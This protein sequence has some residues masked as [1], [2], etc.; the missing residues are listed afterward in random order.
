[1]VSHVVIAGSHPAPAAHYRATGHRVTELSL[2]DPEA[3]A[4][5]TD[6]VDLAIISDIGTPSTGALDGITR[7]DLA[8]A[9]RRYTFA[10]LRIAALLHPRLAAAQGQLVLL[11]RADVTMESPDPAGRWR[12][13]P[14]RAAAHQLWRNLSIEW[15][16]DNITCRILALPD[17]V[18]DPA[19]IATAIAA[20]PAG[21]PVVMT[22]LEGAVVGW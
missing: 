3:A 10:P 14:F 20:P 11:T 1:M 2:D 6:P 17:A 18:L 8:A 5:I 15:Q 13:R 12:D 4:T 9:L 22:D 21:F 16:P 19:A 7:A